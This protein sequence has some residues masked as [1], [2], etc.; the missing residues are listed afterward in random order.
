MKIYVA[1]KFENYKEVEAFE[2]E[3]IKAGHKITYSWAPTARN[4]LEGRTDRGAIKSD[5]ATEDYLGVKN[6]HVFVLLLH[7][8]LQGAL[9]ELGIALGFGKEVWLVGEY[10]YDV[11]FFHLPTQ[12]NGIV[13]LTKTEALEEL[14]RRL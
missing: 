13:R 3:A 4:I 9:V 10:D 2:D 8:G 11:V 14:H 1:S 5:C 6:S 7:P 12:I